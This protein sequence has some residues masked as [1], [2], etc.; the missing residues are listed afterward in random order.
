MNSLQ[1][2]ISDSLLQ[3][4]ESLLIIHKTNHPI[5]T[6]RRRDAMSGI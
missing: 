4:I 3:I 2:L 6:H 5:G 1:C